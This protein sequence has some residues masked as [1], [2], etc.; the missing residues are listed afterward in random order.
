MSNN[1]MLNEATVALQKGQAPATGR[2]LTLPDVLFK[3]AA[4]LGVV[5]IAAVPGA[6]FLAANFWLY[7]GILVVAMIAGFLMMKRAPI[8]AP[9]ALGYSA[10]LGLIV[11]AFTASAVAY[12]GSVAIVPQAVIGTAAG[13][14]G[15]LALYLT[16]W[17]R[18]ASKNYKLF[19]GLMIGYMLIGFIN[20]IF[21][22]T[23]AG[24]GWGLYGMGTWG[25]LLCLFGVAIACY[26][27]L[28]DIGQTDRAIAARADAAY[29][30]TF[31]VSLAASIVW[32]YLELVRLLGISGR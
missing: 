18:K 7:L 8:S 25:I 21:V 27:L 20:L 5:V 3:T 32:L 10:L 30:W 2:E 29:D 6:I 9:L 26:S 11:G 12:G 23:G 31:A 22:L 4:C 19:I 1:R 24:H 17:G 16:P 13:T 14:I 15:M 28:V